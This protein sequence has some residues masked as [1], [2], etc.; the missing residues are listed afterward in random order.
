MK[1]LL[2]VVL[3]NAFSLY[4]V[5]LMFAG[6]SVKGGAYSFLL[7]GLFLTVGNS[8]LSPIVGIITLPFNLLSFGLFSFLTT[9]VSL[10]VI[11]FFFKNIQVSEFVFNG[12]TLW[13]IEI[14]RTSLSIILS[15]LVIS[16]TIYFISKAIQWL[17]S[18]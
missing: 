18:K 13:G 1:K 10:L 8:I 6:L 9:L 17:F 16:A 2:R 15:Y 4:L 3:V 5:S 11:T 7:G 14:K 12:L